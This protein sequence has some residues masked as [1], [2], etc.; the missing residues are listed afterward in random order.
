MTNKSNTKRLFIA[1]EC[2]ISHNQKYPEGRSIFPLHMTLAFISDTPIDDN[3]VFGE[4]LKNCLG[5]IAPCGL[6][7]QIVFLPSDNLRA[8]AIEVQELPEILFEGQKKIT[9][10]LSSL[11][12]HQEKARPFYPHVTLARRPF[13]QGAWK[14]WFKE[15]VVICSDLHL[16]QSKGNLEY[17]SLWQIPFKAPFEEIEHTADFAFLIRGETVAEIF[18]HSQICLMAKFPELIPFMNFET[19]AN[20]N[21]V[22]SLLNKVI[23]C[24]D[25]EIGSPIKAIS[26]HG[27]IEKRDDFLEWEMIIDV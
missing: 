2:T 20:L 12:Y 22:I 10:W 21:K 16:Y 5:K 23:S 6:G 3:I 8:V 11:G 27:K 13:E 19:P 25:E 17:E 18:K 7:R 24:A 14:E 4:E 26:Y 9:A 15:T 1:F